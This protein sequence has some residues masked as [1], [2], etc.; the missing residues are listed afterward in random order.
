MQDPP[1]VI[2]TASARVACSGDSDPAGGHV[3]ALGHPRV[4]MQIEPE[5]GYVDC[6][7]CDR[8]FIL[9]GGVA[10]LEAKAT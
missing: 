7:Y 3:S 1:E 4:W 8:R 5:Q 10:D 9:T 2:R 6:G